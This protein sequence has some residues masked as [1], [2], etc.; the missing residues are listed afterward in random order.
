[1][2]TA[3]KRER[4]STLAN[5]VRDLLRSYWG[6]ALRPEVRIG[7]FG[8]RWIA[9]G[10]FLGDTITPKHEGET[11]LEALRTFR[12]ALLPSTVADAHGDGS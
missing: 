9:Y 3:R 7:T 4:L 6:P 11:P 12:D 2:T 10:T 8:S 1:M 5:E